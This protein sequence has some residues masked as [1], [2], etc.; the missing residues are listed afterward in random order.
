MSE[1]DATHCGHYEV[2][3][4]SY[5]EVNKYKHILHDPGLVYKPYMIRLL[6]LFRV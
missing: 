4:W 3:V 6:I 2:S 1:R 5:T